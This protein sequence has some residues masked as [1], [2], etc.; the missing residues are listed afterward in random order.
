MYSCLFSLGLIHRCNAKVPVPSV[1]RPRAGIC[2]YSLKDK[3][4][5]PLYIKY[6]DTLDDAKAEL[7]PSAHVK[8]EARDP[9]VSQG[10]ISPYDRFTVILDVIWPPSR[11]TPYRRAVELTF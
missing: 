10:T 2:D 5:P 6:P 3:H 4:L 9:L 11:M 1:H 8:K 7:P